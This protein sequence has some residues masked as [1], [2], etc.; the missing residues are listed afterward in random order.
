MK[1]SCAL[2]A[3]LLA[4]GSAL[5]EPYSPEP[6]LAD[7]EQMRQAFETKY[8]NREWLMRDRE[9]DLAALFDRQVKR[10]REA[11]SE[12][13]ARAI[14]DRMI[15]YIGD[16]HV[17]LIWPS[18]ATAAVAPATD[19]CTRLGYNTN[20]TSLG[21]GPSLTGFQRVG[22]ESDPFPAGM[23]TVQGARV[24]VL[25]I[26]MFVPHATP[27]LCESAIAELNIPAD[28][29]CD[30]RCAD[31]I[32]TRAY[33]KLTIALQDQ[34][35][36]LQAA[37]AKQLLVDIVAN[38]GGSEWVH[39]AARVISPRPLQSAPSGF[40]RGEHWSKHWRNLANELRTAAAKAS[41]SDRSKL[42]AWAAEADAARQEAEK[43]C[44]TNCEWLGRAGFATG[45]VAN[46]PSG[47]FDGKP[48]GV[49]VFSPA[50]YPYRDSVWRAP[51]IVLVD[52]YTGSAA[53]D[54]AATLQDNHASVIVGGRTAGAGCGYTNGGTPTTLNNSRAV[55]R[56][57][58]CVR[59]RTDGSNAVNGVIPDVLVG[60][61][62]QDSVK[63]K[64]KLFEAK[65]PEAMQLA[66]KQM[67]AR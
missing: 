47:T 66:E 30:E 3:G 2:F 8:A 5:A 56:L 65:L 24:G 25:R 22:S 52:E 18:P 53:E 35:R 43:T 59:F 12:V 14:F 67:A 63:F 13:A 50:Q 46:A 40:V 33:D 55:L 58:D 15:R 64:A 6:W 28:K 17:V 54:F 29:P 39:A 41:P 9:I 16:G 7:L 37:G 36:A 44:V 34:V 11:D 38:G 45:L 62:G 10:L 48:W 19:V 51:V 26:N 1:L 42:L 60:I 31:A 21:L 20:N 32:L 4:A 27:Q 57:P 61:R 23:I 49:H